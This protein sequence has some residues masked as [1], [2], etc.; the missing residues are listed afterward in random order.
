MNVKINTKE[1]FHEVSVLDAHLSANMAA[2]LVQA[3]TELQNKPPHNLVLNLADVGLID[4]QI[5]EK[6]AQLQ[7][8]FYENSHSFVL[9]HLQASVEKSLD[10]GEWLELLNVTP[11]LSEAWDIVQMEAIEKE[12]LDGYDDGHDDNSN[13]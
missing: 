7:Q 3:L 1:K 2:E 6:I 11:T 12:L 9:C 8:E 4:D 10:D 13:A 5:A